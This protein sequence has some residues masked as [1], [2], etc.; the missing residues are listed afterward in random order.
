LSEETDAVVVAI[1]EETGAISYAYKGQFVRGVTLEALR[2]FLTSVI[3][4][5]AK[6]RSWIAWL[7]AWTRQRIKPGPVVIRTGEPA[8]TTT[9]TTEIAK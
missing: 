6:S 4:T 1:S 8:E 9:T 7:R 3:V 5:P 2:A